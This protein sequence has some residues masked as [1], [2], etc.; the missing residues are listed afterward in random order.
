MVL[1]LS[2]V[3]ISAT[4][5]NIIYVCGLL[6]RLVYLSHPLLIM[7]SCKIYITGAS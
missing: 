5:T 2:V 7:A 4:I 6:L 1:F 3:T